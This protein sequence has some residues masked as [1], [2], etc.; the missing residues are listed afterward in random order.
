MQRIDREGGD[1]AITN[2][3]RQQ[4]QWSVSYAHKAG[5]SEYIA[6]KV[7]VAGNDRY[8]KDGL[9]TFPGNNSKNWTPPKTGGAGV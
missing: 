8:W 3:A 7:L 9:T 4:D 2:L 5:G 6:G 1:A